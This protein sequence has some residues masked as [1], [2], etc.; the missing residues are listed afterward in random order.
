MKLGLGQLLTDLRERRYRFRQPLGGAF[1]LLLLVLARPEWWGLI[2]GSFLCALG[3][4]FRWWAAGHVR[5]SKTLEM[6]GPYSLV[7]HPQYLG[8]S[9]IA[10]GTVL[11]SGVL[12]GIIVW[13]GLFA[14]TYVAA[15]KREDEKLR[16]RFTE[17]WDQWGNKTP[18]VLPVRWPGP[19]PGFHWEDWSFMQAV[20]N[21]EPLWFTGVGVVYLMLWSVPIAGYE[22]F[23]QLVGA[24]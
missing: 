6:K 17:E 4:F 16:R 12:W 8:N 19:N 21:G 1:L 15:I 14:L 18:A 7:R 22:T 2:A 10:L 3:M 20:R 23:R 13:A 5:K 24:L 11:A 9:L